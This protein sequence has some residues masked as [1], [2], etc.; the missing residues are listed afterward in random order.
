[1]FCNRLGTPLDH[2]HVTNQVWYPLLRHLGLAKRRPYQTRHTCATLWLAA[3]ESPQWIANQ[4]GHTTTEMLFRVYAPGL[5]H[6]N[7]IM[8]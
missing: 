8:D 4:L 3:A 5:P 2:K 6:S 7:I 1:M